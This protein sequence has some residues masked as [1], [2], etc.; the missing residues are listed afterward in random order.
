M[1][2]AS[3]SQSRAWTRI[4]PVEAGWSGEEKYHVWS[5]DGSEFLLRVADASNRGTVRFAFAALERL[6]DLPV[7]RAIAQ[8]ELPGKVYTL[9]SWL[10]GVSL[11]EALP[12]LSEAQQ[13]ALG[14]EAGRVLRRL[15]ELPATPGLPD[16][17]ARFNAKLDRKLAAYA[18]CPLRY[19]DDAPLL[20]CIAENRALIAGRP[21]GFQHGDYHVGNFLLA[22][23][24]HLSVIDF[25]R[26]DSG[27]PWEEFNR[28]TWTAEASPAL[29]SGQV[30]GY[31]RGD[32]PERFWRLLAL[33]CAA[34]AVSSLPWAIPYG[35]AEVAT[36]RTQYRRLA[37]WYDGFHSVIPN[38]YAP[39]PTSR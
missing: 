15:H 33:Y 27:D 5:K 31:F 8:G 10:P 20:R 34:N 38:W 25:N 2:F 6:A 3:I 7:P 37:E 11:G 16:W 4:E 39:A 24:G 22:P 29:A 9:L 21:Q 35:E 17:A 13:Y 28:V 36:M 1:R 30:D 26:A 14:L 12:G 19:E 23:D 32:V 18:A